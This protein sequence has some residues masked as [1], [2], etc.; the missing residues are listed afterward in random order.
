MTPDDAPRKAA[1]LRHDSPTH[2]LRTALIALLALTLAVVGG[3]VPAHTADWTVSGTVFPPAE[4]TDT[5][6]WFAGLSVGWNTG[7]NHVVGSDGSFTLSRPGSTPKKIH[8]KDSSGTTRG[9]WLLEDGTVTRWS[10]HSFEFP[11]GATLSIAP[12]PPAALSGHIVMPHGTP[13]RAPR[14]IVSIYVAT[15]TTTSETW[16]YS[17]LDDGAFYFSNFSAGQPYRV[18]VTNRWFGT[19]WLAGDG[20]LSESPT[21]YGTVSSA[22]PATLTFPSSMLRPGISGS[23]VL[24]DGAT[25]YNRVV[26]RAGYTDPDTGKFEVND[27]DLVQPDGTFFL[28]GLEEGQ[29]VKVQLIDWTGRL[30]DGWLAADGKLVPAHADGIEVTVGAPITLRPHLSATIRGKITASAGAALNSHTTIWARTLNGGGAGTYARAEADGTFEVFGLTEGKEYILEFSNESSEAHPA[31]GGYLGAGG[32]FYPYFE[33]GVPITAPAQGVTATLDPFA[34]LGGR[35]ELPSGFAHDATSPPTVQAVH[36]DRVTINQPWLWVPFG[37]PAPVAADGTFSI[38]GGHPHKQYR[39]QL[40]WPDGRVVYWTSDTTVPV[41]DEAEAGT[42]TPRQ[43]IVL[44]TVAAPTPKPEPEPEPE[45]VTRVAPKVTVKTLAK[46]TTRSKVRLRV[47]LDTAGTVAKPT[48]TLRVSYGKKSRTVKVKAKHQGKRTI[49]IPRT[50]ARGKISVQYVPTGTSAVAL[51][52]ATGTVKVAKVAPKVKVKAPKKATTRSRVKVT[53]RVRTALG[54][55]PTGKV[56]I[57]YGKKTRSVR[58]A[59]KDKGKITIR[60][61]RLAKG[62]HTLRVR[63]TPAKTWRPYLKK[64]T[65]KTTVRVR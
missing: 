11:S 36:R 29:N 40:T 59:A 61:P 45:P 35:V 21:S 55:K 58:L 15:D 56:K 10:N 2:P 17:N 63:Y 48:G 13:G 39:L 43:D 49:K 27:V 5:A 18:S 7:D 62:K 34:P 52:P 64:N 22:A 6:E 3:P 9:G 60:L 53:V 44:L 14:S 47:T 38:P 42:T 37:D 8:F 26:V 20:T 65:T 54:A 46:G 31:P 19:A 32:K 23:I 1:A 57:T 50:K 28:G 24:P 41:A 30:H 4:V 51:T 16:N 12:K 25:D 33:D